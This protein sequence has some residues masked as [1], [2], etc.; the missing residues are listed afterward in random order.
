MARNTKLVPVAAIRRLARE[1]AEKFDP[2]RIILFGSYAYG[3]PNE[4]SDVDLLV[5]MPATNQIRQ[6]IRIRRATEH[7]FPLDLLVRTPA[8]LRWRLEEGDWFLREV[9]EKGRVL[10]E[11]A[12]RRMGSKGR[13]RHPRGPSARRSKTA[14]E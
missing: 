8:T 9:V 5:V 7:P 1:I 11:Q 10:Y 4:H 3:E 14:L 6:A 2:D 12:H 13:G